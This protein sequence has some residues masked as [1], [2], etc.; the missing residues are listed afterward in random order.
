MNCGPVS[1]S[2]CVCTTATWAVSCW[3]VELFGDD[4]PE[5]LVI[6]DTVIGASSIESDWS[7]GTTPITDTPSGVVLV[8]RI[9]FF[10]KYKVIVL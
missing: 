3:D 10:C 4:A 8:C 7:I 5:L 6:A 2:V 9:N 1:L